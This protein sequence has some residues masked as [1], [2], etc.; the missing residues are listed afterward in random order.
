MLLK[1]LIFNSQ[2]DFNQSCSLESDFVLMNTNDS[3]RFVFV[4]KEGNLS[5]YQM[6]GKHLGNSLSDV[7]SILVDFIESGG[8]VDFV[9]VENEIFKNNL[10]LIDSKMPELL[11]HL[12]LLFYKTDIKMTFDLSN[13][14]IRLNPLNYD[15]K[16]SH[17]FY[18]SKIK[19]FLLELALGM[20]SSNVWSGKYNEDNL[21]T[22][23]LEDNRLLNYQINT[24]N[25][26]EEFLFMNTQLLDVENNTENTIFF[27]SDR[28][29]MYLSLN[30][31]IGVI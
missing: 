30:L 16:F 4:L 31:R 12:I 26:F 14:L 9:K 17:F 5:K 28:S 10:I 2:L 20:N 19:R 24:H 27:N 23:R 29:E 13:E 7:K 1:T 11:A 8:S 15:M 3:T 18:E 22:L 21:P 6:I 25:I